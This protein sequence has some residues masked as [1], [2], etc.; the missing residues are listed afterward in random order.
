MASRRRYLLP[1][2]ALTSALLLTPAAGAPAH[3]ALLEFVE[4]QQRDVRGVTGLAGVLA[5]AVSADGRNVY[6]A[7]GNDD[8]VA[9]FDRDPASGALTFTQVVKDG[10]D[11]V[12]GLGFAS[13]LALSP[14]GAHVYVTGAR[15]DAVAV[16]ARDSSTGALTFVEMQKDGDAG[17]EGLKHA[18]AVVVSPDG[19]F[20]YVAGQLDDAIAVFR[21]NALTGWLTFVAVLRE[22]VDG[23]HGIAGPLGLALSADGATLYVASGDGYAV[24]VLKRDAATGRLRLA[25]VEQ[26]G[27][28]NF[29]L[30][31]I[32]SVVVSPDGAHVYAAAQGDSAVVT[33]RRNKRT[34]ALTLADAVADGVD[35]VEGLHGAL[36]AAVSPDGTKLYVASTH[37]N[38]VAAF[39]RDPRSGALSF[40]E[41]QKGSPECLAYAR[42]V[43]VSPDGKNVYVAGASS[44]A[45]AVFR[46]SE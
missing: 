33:F 41:M 2:L 46:V 24:G 13:A 22:G 26:E 32:H 40:I 19:S 38:A 15:D 5:V 10:F 45:V 14:D 11:G 4:A 37:D 8:A 42:A 35:D 30:S 7:G 20:V 31:G 12:E 9:V 6:A 16:F 44:N 23:V 27:A 43:A 3:A 34:G 29:G 39:D 25:D 17:V 1:Y 18:S 36:R 28:R 21:R